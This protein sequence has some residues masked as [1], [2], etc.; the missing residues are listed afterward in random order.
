MGALREL[1]FI[2]GVG[3][4]VVFLMIWFYDSDARI[5]VDDSTVGEARVDDSVQQ[6]RINLSVECVNNTFNVLPRVFNLSV[7][8]NDVDRIHCARYLAFRQYEV[9]GKT[10]DGRSFYAHSAGGGM[11]ASG[12]DSLRDRCLIVDNVRLISK[13][14]TG[15]DS[16]ESEGTCQWYNLDYAELNHEYVSQK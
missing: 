4:C 3:L 8:I 14:V 9:E 11:A 2:L 1:S 7:D 5:S 16:K 6:V 12:A 15:R 13:M 10:V